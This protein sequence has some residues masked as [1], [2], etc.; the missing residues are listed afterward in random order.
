M[1]IN[2]KLIIA[3]TREQLNEAI[4]ARNDQ[5]KKCFGLCPII[6]ILVV[7]KSLAIRLA[8]ASGIGALTG[9]AL[10][11]VSLS[12]LIAGGIIGLARSLVSFMVV[13]CYGF[14][15][16]VSSEEIE[17]DM[18]EEHKRI[19]REYSNS[20]EH[21]VKTCIDCITDIAVSFDANYGLADEERVGNGRFFAL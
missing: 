5:L 9:L 13:A 21:K 3:Y 8:I 1:I 4:Q 2:F 17:E 11:Y 7:A 12:P 19:L 14:K 10:S 18:S 6:T 20:T 16:P 15:I